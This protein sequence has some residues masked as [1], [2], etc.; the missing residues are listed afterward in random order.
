MSRRIR[1][2]T[3]GRGRR[4]LRF[5][6][7]VT[8][9]ATMSVLLWTAPASS[10]PPPFDNQR[11]DPSM[12]VSSFTGNEAE[13]VSVTE[14]PGSDPNCLVYEVEKS[15]ET[16][17]H[18]RVGLMDGAG[19]VHVG[20]NFVGSTAT[21]TVGVPGLTHLVMVG[22]FAAP[23]YYATPPTRIMARAALPA[24]SRLGC[25]PEDVFNWADPWPA[26]PGWGM[27][28]S[29]GLGSC[30]EDPN[31]SLQ[32]RGAARIITHADGTREALVFARHTDAKDVQLNFHR[33]YF[34]TPWTGQWT[35]QVA[36]L[37]GRQAVLQA[38]EGQW[39][40][41]T[42]RADGDVSSQKFA[43]R[44]WRIDNPGRIDLWMDV[45]GVAQWV[46]LT[47]LSNLPTNID[48]LP[49]TLRT[50]V[51]LDTGT[52]TSVTVLVGAD[53]YGSF[54]TSAPVG[55]TVHSG[56]AEGMTF[57]LEATTL[58]NCTPPGDQ[59]TLS[60]DLDY[61]GILVAS[62]SAS[63]PIPCIENTAALGPQCGGEYVTVRTVRGENPSVF[64]D[65]VQA[66]DRAD[67]IN[68][69]D[70]DDVI[71]AEGGADAIEGGAG[72]DR[73]YGGDGDD[74]IDGGLDVDRIWGQ[75]GN[76]FILGGGGSD[77][78][79][80]GDGDDDVLAGSGADWVWGQAGDD[81]IAG[82]GGRDRLRGG[83]GDDRL[84]G[85]QQSDLIFGDAGD[86]WLYGAG[87]KDRAY[88]GLG[89][90]MLYGGDNTDYLHGGSGVDVANGQAG[91]D[92]PLVIDVSGCVAEIK[93]SC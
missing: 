74:L 55:V 9:T 62:C 10:Q 25:V 67:T 46:E 44:L 38:A 27:D 37:P 20:D 11:T 28:T 77:R 34:G 23:G 7:A 8:A 47:T 51:D 78:I 29:E 64:A 6:A 45:G 26:N 1:K 36:S 70:G 50:A 30:S 92:N 68:S 81:F 49:V 90:D 80:G 31:T 2:F 75:A 19:G 17:S 3:A 5:V 63:T 35:F 83:T 12:L 61:S 54:L 22:G 39:A 15:A 88:G 93:K 69:L 76:D 73:I 4:L 89:N 59:L 71:C 58:P 53:V 18:M 66:S 48:D 41:N 87:G 86:D 43:A 84:Q 14:V 79:F 57:S 42:L 56:W 21:M 65:V 85:N 40:V 24:P 32:D 16:R 13:I 52:Y 72:R 33:K 60:Y 91:H 82:G